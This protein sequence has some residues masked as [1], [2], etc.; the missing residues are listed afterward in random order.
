MNSEKSNIENLF[1]FPK[2]AP[3]TQS[4]FDNLSKL[5]DDFRKTGNTDWS[6]AEAFLC[7]LISAAAADGVLAKEEMNEI[8][9]LAGRSRVLKT[10]NPQQ[11]AAINET[12]RQRLAKRPN[13]LQEAC[14]ILPAE[15]RLPLFAHCADIILSDGELRSAEE[16]FLK[17]LVGL[18]NLQASESNLILQALLIKN[19]F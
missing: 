1:D 2:A 11:L 7:L 8:Q 15:M 3:P 12:V 9:A 5:A 16:E 4:A 18:L 19:R 6:V 13:G 10:L 14:A 17:K